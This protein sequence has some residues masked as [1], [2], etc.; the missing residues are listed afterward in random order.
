[1]LMAVRPDHVDLSMTLETDR[2]LVEHYL[3][4]PRHLE[5]RRAT[6]NKYI[7][8]FTNAADGSN[9]PETTASAERGR[10]LLDTI[11]Q[12]LAERAEN[13]LAELRGGPKGL[14]CRAE[15]TPPKL[16]TQKGSSLIRD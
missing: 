13:L 16:R 7:G 4:E 15:G 6:P 1:M 9:D 5:Q 2:A 14:G 3:G 8:L 12:R 11:A 10:L